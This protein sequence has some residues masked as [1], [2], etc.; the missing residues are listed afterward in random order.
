MVTPSVVAYID[1]EH[2]D[3]CAKRLGGTSNSLFSGMA[4]RLGELLG[5]VDGD[6]LVNLS[7]PVSE[8]TEGDTRANALMAASMTADPQQVRTDLSGVRAAMKQAL[9]ESAQESAKMTGPLPL[10]PLTPRRL[11]RRLEGMVLAVNNPIACSNMGELDPAFCRP[12][13][14]DA[15]YVSMRALE[16]QITSRA[17]NRIGGQLLLAGARAGGRMAL[18]VGSW[19]V[20]GVNSKEALRDVVQRA[21]DDFGLTG[22]IEGPRA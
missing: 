14:T 17:L 16:P 6:G 2:W 3:A 19:T 18:V 20:G 12:D 21:L 9:A 8:R 22:T 1:T 5:R 13:G 7:W 11:L 15:D 10:T 4:A